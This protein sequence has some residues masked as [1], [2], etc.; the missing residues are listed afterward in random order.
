MAILNY[1]GFALQEQIQSACTTEHSAEEEYL[2]SCF[3]CCWLYTYFT[4]ILHLISSGCGWN[5]A[6]KRVAGYTSCAAKHGEDHPVHN[7]RVLLTKRSQAHVPHSTS[8]TWTRKGSVIYSYW[9]FF[10]F[11]RIDWENGW[12]WDYLELI[13]LSLQAESRRYCGRK[14]EREMPKIWKST[15]MFGYKDEK[16]LWKAHRAT[17]HGKS[18]SK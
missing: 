17:F 9:F 2:Y 8:I 15:G 14:K 4:L 6:E 18:S 11:Q 16:S 3:K 13:E 1:L 10:L 12:L 5:E 7:R